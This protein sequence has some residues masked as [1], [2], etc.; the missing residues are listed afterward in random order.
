MALSA[1][2]GAFLLLLALAGPAAAARSPFL[3]SPPY[4]GPREIVLFGHLSSL[5]PSGSRR[6]TLRFDPAIQLTG[7]T[8]SAYALA[9]TGSPD[10]PNDHITV[11]PDHQLLTFVVPASARATV[12]TNKHNVG[13]KATPVSIATLARAVAGHAPRALG[14][15]EP[16]APFWIVVRTDTVVELDQQYVP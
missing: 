11:D 3:P 2:A 15:F 4:G 8:A 5:K 10:V 12:I 9:K 13:I 6:Y 7:K 16:P 1:R 14:L